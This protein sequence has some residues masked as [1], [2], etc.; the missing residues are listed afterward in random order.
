M[1]VLSLLRRRVGIDIHSGN[2]YFIVGRIPVWTLLLVP[3]GFIAVVA[4]LSV[5]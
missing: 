4:W 3:V 2:R 1:N 5:R